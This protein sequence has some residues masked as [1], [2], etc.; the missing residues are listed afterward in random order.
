MVAPLRVYA[1][2]RLEALQ[3]SV[4]PNLTHTEHRQW[5]LPGAGV[6]RR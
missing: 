3:R 4:T 6:A 1:A 2:G 5:R